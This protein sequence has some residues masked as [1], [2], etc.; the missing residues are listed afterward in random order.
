MRLSGQT[1]G[2]Q[3]HYIANHLNFSSAACYNSTLLCTR[4]R[5]FSTKARHRVLQPVAARRTAIATDDLP[6]PE[7]PADALSNF[8]SSQP[9]RIAPKATPTDVKKVLLALVQLSAVVALLILLPVWF[10]CKQVPPRAWLAAAL[11]SVFFGFGG[12]RRTL[13]YGKLTSR[14]N[15]AQVSTT[16]GKRAIVLFVLLVVAGTASDR[17]Y[18]WACIS[19]LRHHMQHNGIHNPCAQEAL[20]Y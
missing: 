18:T 2:P 11:Y 7:F 3:R 15:D 9:R 16:Q 14:K 1:Q 5:P 4:R 6:D 10:S 8:R 13:K 20:L 19:G 17:F 12:L